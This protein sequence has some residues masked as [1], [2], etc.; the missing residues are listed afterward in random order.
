MR[1]SNAPTLQDVA[2]EVGVSATTASIVLHGARSTTRVSEATR[3]RI[4]EVAHRLRY[5]PNA[6]ARGL[7]R[8]R[9]DTLGVVAIIDGGE[10]NFY[11]LEVLN[12][13]LEAAA[14][15]GQNTTIF[16][17]ANWREDE[18]RILK[19]CD[20]RV[21]GM[22]L[23]APQYMPESFAETLL[24]HTPFVTIHCNGMPPNIYNLDVDNEGGAYTVV[25]YLI[26]QGHRRIAHFTGALD[27][28]GP[29]QRLAG[30]RRALEEAGV[31]YD[32]TQVIEG[33][34]SINS[35]RVRMTRLLAERRS[36][37]LPT[38]IFCANDS[39]ACGCLEVMANHNL[40]APDDISIAGF[41]DT[42]A[43]RTTSPPLTTAQQPLYGMGRRAVE[44]LLLQI[45]EDAELR[46][47][48]EPGR[49]AVVES[50]RIAHETPKSQDSPPLQPG[51]TA[52]ILPHTEIFQVA[53]V[54]RGSVAPPKI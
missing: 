54:V 45:R 41:D 48:R 32:E 24:H 3:A 47:A 14:H 27:Q 4:L 31:P 1:R 20:G 22:I 16:S 49:V 30:Y 13:I 34:F 40:S 35:G 29:R 23:L 52:V 33:H 51:E 10:P 44:L 43:A 6:V 26:S 38:A 39:I 18:A 21:D 5:R 50:D 25:R 17:I 9:M 11:F 12:G 37:E 8:R 7:H 15:N 53:L 28:F 46:E 19:F 2:R 42:L 36:T